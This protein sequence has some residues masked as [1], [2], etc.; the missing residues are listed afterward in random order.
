[1]QDVAANTA[2]ALKADKLILVG[3]GEGVSTQAGEVL[4]EISAAQA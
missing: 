4:S 1:M 3:T 2:I